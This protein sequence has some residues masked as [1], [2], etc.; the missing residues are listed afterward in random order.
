MARRK[1]AA[2]EPS[3][4]FEVR[5]NGRRVAVAGVLGEGNLNA[6][7]HWSRTTHYGEGPWTSGGMR[8]HVVGGDFNDPT[9]DRF[10]TWADRPLKLGDRVEIDV[11]EGAKPDRGRQTRFRRTPLDEWPSRRNPTYVHVRGAELYAVSD[12][13]WLR[14]GRAYRGDVSLSAQQARKLGRGLLDAADAVARRT[15]ARKETGRSRR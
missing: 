10:S 8:L 11:V 3:P 14:V 4:C 15:N 5:V 1:W 2:N 7:L 13:V 12:G 6:H 9:W